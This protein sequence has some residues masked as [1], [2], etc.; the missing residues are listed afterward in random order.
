MWKSIVHQTFGISISDFVIPL[1]SNTRK[2]R[3]EILVNKVQHVVNERIVESPCSCLISIVWIPF[4]VLCKFKGEKARNTL[5]KW[6]EL[7]PLHIAASV[8]ACRLLIKRQVGKLQ[9]QVNAREYSHLSDYLRD[10]PVLPTESASLL[11]LFILPREFINK[12]ATVACEDSTVSKISTKF[13]IY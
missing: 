10:T 2:I 8:I 1:Y 5:N 11:F 7:Y 4:F 12:G 13:N 9:T 6:K 3:D